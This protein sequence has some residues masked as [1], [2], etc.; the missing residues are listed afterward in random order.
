MHLHQ[1]LCLGDGGSCLKCRFVGLLPPPECGTL[2]LAWASVSKRWPAALGSLGSE[3]PALAAPGRE[4]VLPEQMPGTDWAGRK[5]GLQ[6]FFFYH[7][8]GKVFFLVGQS[9]LRRV[10]FYSPML[11]L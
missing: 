4:E 3:D 1:A 6:F 7:F 8:E 9:T 10:L 2:G 11:V 5:V